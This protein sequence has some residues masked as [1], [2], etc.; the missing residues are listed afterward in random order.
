MGL[1]ECLLGL[2]TSGRVSVAIEADVS[3]TDRLWAAQLLERRAEDQAL[4][5]PGEPPEFHAGAA[6]DAALAVY[7]AARFTVFRRESPAHIRAVL[8]RTLTEPEPSASE[9]WSADIVLPAMA[10]VRRR[11][12][13][14]SGEDP[15]LREIDALLQRRPLS[16]AALGPLAAS[17]ARDTPGLRAILDDPCLRRLLVDRLM[18]CADRAGIERLGLVADVRAA[19]GAW[20][21]LAP[22]L[23]DLAR[24]AKVE[25]GRETPEPG[26]RPPEESP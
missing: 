18:A 12:A 2:W 24:A 11:A 13:R 10:G 16:A 19:I 22:G 5:L 4:E 1:P 7:H 9:A 21:E 25:T 23:E 3:D 17:I 8:G 14:V 6:L 26:G 20:P 15:L